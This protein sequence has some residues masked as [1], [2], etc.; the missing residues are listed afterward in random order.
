MDTQASELVGVSVFRGILTTLFGFAAVFWP[1]LTGRTLVFLFSAFILAMGVVDLISGIGKLLHGTESILTRV[2][3]PLLGA[4]EIGVG[5]YLLRHVDVRLSVF[6]LLLGFSFLLR[7]I[8][9]VVEGLFTEGPSGNRVLLIIVGVLSALAGVII[10][11]QPVAG[12]IAFVWV[13]GIYALIT[14]PLMIALAV[15]VNK[16]AKLEDGK[17]R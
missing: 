6:I 11:M 12:G 10:L 16:A 1:G 8:F 14:G 4:L 5:V 13:L 17:K 2:L 9:E 3:T 7:G 15:E